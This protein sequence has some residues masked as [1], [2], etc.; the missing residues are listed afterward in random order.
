MS[1]RN[2]MTAHDRTPPRPSILIQGIGAMGGVFAARLIE[3]GFAPT[4]V[5]GLRM[6]EALN[7]RGITLHSEGRAVRQ[8]VVAYP[9]VSDV[10][11]DL[12]FD[13]V[14]ILTK[15]T[16][17]PDA[18][19]AVLERS[20]ESTIF[21]ALQNGIVEP[22][23]AAVV[24]KAR[25]IW[26]LL[27][28]S[29]T[30]HEPG[31]YEQTT[32]MGTVL[33]EV[34]GAITP[35]LQRLGTVFEHVAPVFLS[36][37][38]SGAQWAKLQMNCSVTELGTLAGAPLSDVLASGPGRRVFVEVCSEV[39]NVADAEGVRLETLV[40]DPYVPRSSS[41]AVIDAWLDK[42][43]SRYGKSR[44][45]LRQDLDRGRPTEIDYLTGYVAERAEALSVPAPRCTAITQMIHEIE[46]GH[47]TLGMSNLMDL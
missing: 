32:R 24:G 25:V 22:R 40:L 43:L 47:R 38:I 17:A 33:G 41:Q 34:K 20:S 11:P 3:E 45:S 4:L 42:I 19:R 18:A 13:V 12:V 14:L 2:A 31:V 8:R 44:P 37:N 30:M 15:A 26:S 9:S 46:A 1:Q 5:A 21:V 29:A 16:A 28:W 27:N 36:T 7:E 39:L 6:A 35:R 23:V 10:P